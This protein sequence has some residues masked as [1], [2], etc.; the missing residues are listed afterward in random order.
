MKTPG[1]RFKNKTKGIASSHC[2][3]VEVLTARCWGFNAFSESLRG[4]TVTEGKFTHVAHQQIPSWLWKTLFCKWLQ[5]RWGNCENPV[6]FSYELGTPSGI[7]RDTW[8]GRPLCERAPSTVPV[9][10]CSGRVSA[11]GQVRENLGWRQAGMFWAEGMLTCSRLKK[12]TTMD[13]RPWEAEKKWETF[14]FPCLYGSGKARA[15]GLVFLSLL[16]ALSSLQQDFH[17][18]REID[19]GYHT[20]QQFKVFFA[21]PCMV[22]HLDGLQY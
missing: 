13:K 1:H 7:V 18:C 6:L 3:T 10:C 21:W 11:V 14:P 9:R 5:T 15:L 16:P 8:L 4:G 2:Y 20:W 17:H 12:R 19:D 22:P